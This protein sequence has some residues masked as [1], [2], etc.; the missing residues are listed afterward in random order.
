[1]EVSIPFNVPSLSA[2]VDFCFEKYPVLSPQD[3]G[4]GSART[5]QSI[6]HSERA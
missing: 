2:A 1:M 3:R 6:R 4:K 5:F